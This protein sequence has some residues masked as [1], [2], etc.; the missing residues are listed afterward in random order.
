FENPGTCG[1]VDGMPGVTMNDGRQTFM[2]LIYGAEKYP[3]NDYWAADCDG[4]L[5]I[6]MNDGRQIF[7][8][9]IYG[10]E[11]YPLVCE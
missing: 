11:D 7:M 3:I 1:D 6:T 9:L 8:N 5:G 2:N 4:S 10:E